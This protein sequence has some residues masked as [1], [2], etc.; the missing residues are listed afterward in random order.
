MSVAVAGGGVAAL[1]AALALNALAG[2]R[3]GLTLVAPNDAF[4]YQPMA[5]WE[6]FF[7]GVGSYRDVP[8]TARRLSLARFAGDVG[9][10]LEHDSVAS[11]D[12]ER[13]VL[14]TGAGR[15]LS[16][17]ALV[18]ATGARTSQEL[19]AAIALDG[20][21]IEESL[22][23]LI[24]DIESGSVQSVA[25]VV[26]SRTTWP[27]PVYEV[28]LL[29]RERARE[30]GIELQVTI[31]TVEERPLAVFGSEASARVAELLS[32][33]GID[34]VVAASVALPRAGEL[35]VHP[36]ERRLRFDRVVAVSRLVGPS[37][38]GLPSDADGFLPIGA[39]SRVQGAERVYAAGD[40][41]DF[42]VKY[43][44]VAS[45]QADAAARSI[46]ALAGLPVEPEPL[47][48]DVHGTLL[49]SRHGTYLR[50]SARLEEGVA[51]DSRVS[52]APVGE[53]LP[54]K[55]VARYLAPYLDELW[56][57]SPSSDE[58]TWAFLDPPASI[59]AED[60]GSDGDENAGA[61]R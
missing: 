37:I 40:A 21:A 58:Q 49:T 29:T 4:V 26:S 25:F 14:R 7:R 44:G 19:P 18:I 48:T 35:T 61:G 16:Y 50:L 51:R 2:R 3:V 52:E 53:A 9:A 46:A 47:D 43:G 60:R 20:R 1:E 56:V 27:L 17:D 10:V 6:P 22:R 32:E 15:E 45:Q 8:W 31:V 33:A 5:V 28:A 36:G 23:G 59:P 24:S 39:D 30:I 41:T 34:T 57:V 38:A 11:V 55:I 42:P 54:A 13:Q 12:C